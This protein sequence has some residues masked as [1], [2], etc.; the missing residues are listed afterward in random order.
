MMGDMPTEISAPI[1]YVLDGAAPR[2]ALHMHAAQANAEYLAALFPY[3]PEIPVRPAPLLNANRSLLL[4]YELIEQAPRRPSPAAT[5]AS[6]V[7]G[8][9][10][11]SLG[12]TLLLR[13]GVLGVQQRLAPLCTVSGACRKHGGIAYQLAQCFALLLL[14]DVG[15]LVFVGSDWTSCQH[16]F[17]VV[18]WE[19]YRTCA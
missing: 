12:S 8:A 3:F 16:S 1:Y 2:P 17:V 14:R 9:R 4:A 13:A 6:T 5:L 19:Q 15:Y 11:L 7:L 10:F 18:G